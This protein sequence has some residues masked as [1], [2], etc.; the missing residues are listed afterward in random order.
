MIQYYRILLAIDN[1]SP[2]IPRFKLTSEIEPRDQYGIYAL[3]NNVNDNAEIMLISEGYT[4]D[5]NIHNDPN[6]DEAYI[7]YIEFDTFREVHFS[8]Y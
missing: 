5:E 2:I 6:G 7:K 8:F 3:R 4:A 1:N